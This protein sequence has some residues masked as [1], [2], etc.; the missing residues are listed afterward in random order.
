MSRVTI[1]SAVRLYYIILLY[2]T[3]PGPDLHYALGYIT[4]SVEINLAIITASAPALWPLARRWFPG[5][6]ERIGINRERGMHL[7]PYIEVAYA[8]PRSTDSH[9][10]GGRMLRGKVTWHQTQRVPTG[11]ID[12]AVLVQGR[13][14]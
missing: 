5:A 7:Y 8:T 14:G 12:A 3:V 10:S 2:Y 4:S 1:I 13:R 11:A 9:G 6:F